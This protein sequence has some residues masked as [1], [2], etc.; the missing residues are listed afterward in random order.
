MLELPEAVHL[1][2]QLTDV[3]A[4]RRIASA[5]CGNRPHKWVW[6]GP[7]A[8][9]LPVLL[10]GAE[11]VRA[12]GVARGIRV[13]LADGRL[14]MFDEF[15]GRMR[16]HRPGDALPATYHFGLLLDDGAQLSLAVQGWG[17]IRVITPDE[18]AA[19]L[20]ERAV[21]PLDEGFTAE[22]V[23]ALLADYEPAKEP[24]KAWFTNSRSVLGIG[25][26]YLQDI[27]LRAGVHPR[28]KVGSITADE[29]A[30]LW[31]GTRETITAAVAAGG[32]RTE[33]D[34][35]DQRGG[36]EPL[37]DRYRKGAPC[38]RCGTMIESFSFLG[39]SCYV[40]PTCQP[41]P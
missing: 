16:Y 23:T 24:I 18:L 29:A 28:R 11:P 2:A 9:E 38:P 32:R 20:G 5:S 35:Y 41:K 33:F 30:A 7:S 3:L 31:R 13:D 12:S 10:A 34:L 4:G 27:L 17:G 25:N 39:G 19:R 21:S 15:G 22:R 14:L 26:G 1:A 8:E 36:Y 40:C 6:Y 37:L